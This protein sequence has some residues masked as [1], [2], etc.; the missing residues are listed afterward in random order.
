MK[1]LLSA[2]L[3]FSILLTTCVAF[4]ACK[5]RHKC[6]ASDEWSHNAVWHWH[7]CADA[8]CDEML[9]KQDHTWDEGR[10]TREP[11]QDTDGVK[12]YTCTVC[13]RTRVELVILSD[14]EDAQ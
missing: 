7:A 6:Q 5:Q 10:I 4:A 3:I 13:S 1:K 12:T 11:T 9:D 14:L 8:E 2:M